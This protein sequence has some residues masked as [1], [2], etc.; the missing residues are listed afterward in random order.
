MFMGRPATKRIRPLVEDVDKADD[1]GPAAV[2]ILG[3]NCGGDEPLKLRRQILMD[4]LRPEM[5]REF[6]LSLDANNIWEDLYR[7]WQFSRQWWTEHIREGHDNRHPLH[8]KKFDRPIPHCSISPQAGP[9]NV[10]NLRLSYSP[11]AP[12]L[13]RGQ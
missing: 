10:G 12:G 5:E 3:R 11:S 7:F 4:Q 1:L 13:H 2:L 9:S 6:H 8:H